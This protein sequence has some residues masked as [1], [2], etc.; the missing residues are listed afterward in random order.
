M[1]IESITD[2]EYELLG[3]MCTHFFKD[4]YHIFKQEFINICIKCNNL[5]GALNCTYEDIPLNISAG[6]YWNMFLKWRLAIGK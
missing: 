1:W 6:D 5:I 2:K 4:Y 3:D